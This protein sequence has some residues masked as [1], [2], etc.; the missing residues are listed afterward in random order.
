MPANNGTPILKSLCLTN[1]SIP[2]FFHIIAVKNPLT[3]KKSGIR[4]P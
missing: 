4:N 2:R 1:P 3:K